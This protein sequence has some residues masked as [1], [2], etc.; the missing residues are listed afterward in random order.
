LALQVQCKLLIVFRAGREMRSTMQSRNEECL[1]LAEH[2]EQERRFCKETI[3]RF[4]TS[5]YPGRSPLDEAEWASEMI[6]TYSFLESQHLF[7]R[8]M[9]VERLRQSHQGQVALSS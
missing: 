3:E 6:E 8:E 1:R 5:D 9:F 7:Y 4:R 2:H